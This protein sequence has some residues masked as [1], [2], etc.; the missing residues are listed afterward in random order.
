MRQRKL[1]RHTQQ[2]RVNAMAAKRVSTLCSRVIT[3]SPS[4]HD[5]PNTSIRLCVPIAIMEESLFPP[6]IGDRNNERQFYYSATIATMVTSSVR[7]VVYIGHGIIALYSQNTSKII[8][9]GL[10]SNI[11]LGGMP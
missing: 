11:F 10:K 1:K 6:Y 4:H 7:R 2:F 8:S 3:T 9:E 5:K